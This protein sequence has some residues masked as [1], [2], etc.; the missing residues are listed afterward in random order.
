MISRLDPR[1]TRAERD[2]RLPIATSLWPDS[3]G[4]TSGNSA[5]RSVDKSTSM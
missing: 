1:T 4:A 2:S 3:S 5:L